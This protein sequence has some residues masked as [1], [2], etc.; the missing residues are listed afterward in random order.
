MTAVRADVAAMLRNGAT[1]D[2]IKQQ[3]HVSGHTIARVRD[4]LGIPVPADRAKRTRAELAVL[5]DQAVV[6]LRNGATYAEIYN[7]LRLQPNRIAQ[8]R[9]AH[10]IPVPDR[11]H[12][13]TQRRTVEEAFA[14][15]TQPSPEGGHLLWTGPRRGRTAELSASGRRYNARTVAFTKHHGRE[16]EG[17]LR[18]TTDCSHPDCIAG[19]HLTDHRIRQAHARADLAFDQIFGPNA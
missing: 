1:F 12:G 18:R 13:A 8:L 6:M 14:L 15:Y 16:P 17:R 2:E 7:A 10:N 19:A 4:V 9:K 5:E 11:D 3:L